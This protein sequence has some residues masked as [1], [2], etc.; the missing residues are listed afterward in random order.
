MEKKSKFFPK[1]LGSGST[2]GG[3][4]AVAL[5][6]FV[7]SSRSKYASYIIPILLLVASFAA[8]IFGFV[9]QTKANRKRQQ[10]KK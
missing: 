2:F 3:I 7:N 4:L 5:I 8:V 9:R 10:G 1:F 6:T